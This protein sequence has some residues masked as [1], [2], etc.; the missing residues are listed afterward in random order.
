MKTPL[1]EEKTKPFKLVKYFTFT[2]LTVLFIGTIILSLF[3]A[4]WARAIQ[5]KKS[6]EYALL[7]IENLKSSTFQALLLS[8]K[9]KH[10][11]LVNLFKEISQWVILR[12]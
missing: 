8:S 12:I 6:E 3:N 5:Q 1:P 7:L 2:S 4:H 9:Q 11:H 10:A